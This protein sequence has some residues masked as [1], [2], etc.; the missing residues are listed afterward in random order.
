MRLRFFLFDLSGNFL[1]RHHAGGMIEQ[2]NGNEETAVL[3]VGRNIWTKDP[4]VHGLLLLSMKDGSE[5]RR[6][7]TTGPCVASA[8][9][10]DNAYCAAVEA[11][12]KLDNGEIIGDYRLHLWRL[13]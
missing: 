2:L 6:F 13:K 8:L 3:A 5:L 9:S 11:P 10:D 4:L 12:L 7:T 1:A